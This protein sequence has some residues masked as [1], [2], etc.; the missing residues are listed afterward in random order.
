YKKFLDICEYHDFIYKIS[1]KSRSVYTEKHNSLS[2]HNIF[3]KQGE[4]VIKAEMIKP[5][6]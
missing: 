5:E 3:L 2:L 4:L 1:K 6:V